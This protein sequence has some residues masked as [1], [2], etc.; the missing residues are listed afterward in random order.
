MKMKLTETILRKII[1]EQIDDYLEYIPPTEGIPGE[2]SSS[3]SSPNRPERLRFTQRLEACVQSGK[4]IMLKVDVKTFQRNASS[5]YPTEYTLDGEK[6]TSYRTSSIL[7]TK[8]ESFKVLKFAGSGPV[9]SSHVNA[10]VVGSP[11]RRI[12]R[13]EENSVVTLQH[14]KF[15]K[16]TVALMPNEVKFG[17]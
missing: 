10:E 3:D 17:R 7:P 2:D 14:E 16:F 6:R 1:K 5:N 11:S 8:G 4:P 13:S 15:G 9:W 12:T